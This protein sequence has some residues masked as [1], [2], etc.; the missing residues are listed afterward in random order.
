MVATSLKKHAISLVMPI[1]I[2]ICLI[3][4]ANAEENTVLRFAYQDRIGSVIPIVAE[5]KGFYSEEGLTVKTL[6][7]SSGPACAEALYSGSADVAGMGDTAAIIMV[8]RNP[9]FV[10]VASHA[11]GEH[12]HRIM[13]KKDSTIQDINDLKGKRL[14][15]KKGTSTYGGLLAALKKANIPPTDIDIIDLTPPTM[16][17]A[18]MAGSIDAFAASEPTPS[19]AEEK[20]ARELMTLGGLGNEYPI[21]TVANGDMLERNKMAVL[22][23]LKAMKKAEVYAKNNPAEVVAMMSAETGLSP[24]TTRKAMQ[25]HEYQLRLDASIFFSLEQTAHFLKSQGIISDLPDFTK[26]AQNGL[27]ETLSN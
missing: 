9:K 3:G 16:T 11:N 6:R 26:A 4:V 23:L 12:R 8:A 13:V 5:K 21:L 27:I 14:G 22:K 10:I 2:L 1:I 20:G 24:E 19:S 18:L 7:F 25:R 15:V 17:E